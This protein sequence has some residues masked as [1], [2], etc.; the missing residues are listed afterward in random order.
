[1]ANR[2]KKVKIGYDYVHTAIDD[3]TRLAYSEVQS[4]ERDLTCAEFLHR[5]LTWFAA[6]GVRIRRLLTDNAL[7]YRRGTVWGWVCSTLATPTPIHQTRLPLDQR[8]SRTLQ[9]HPAHRMGLRPALGVKQPAC[10]RP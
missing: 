10:T 3:Y 7:V 8:Q 2:H 5:A 9:P 1:V 4:D 6:H